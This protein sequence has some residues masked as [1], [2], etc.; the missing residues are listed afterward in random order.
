MGHTRK[1][2]IFAIAP[3]DRLARD[4]E[5]TGLDLSETILVPI[6]AGVDSSWDV[7]DAQVYNASVHITRNRF[8]EISSLVHQEWTRWSANRPHDPVRRYFSYVFNITRTPILHW[9]MSVSLALER[10]KPTEVY[11]Y[12]VGDDTM[13]GISNRDEFL[14]WVR[15]AIVSE[16]RPDVIKVKTSAQRGV[17]ILSRAKGIRMDMLLDFPWYIGVRFPKLMRILQD[18][19]LRRYSSEKSSNFAGRPRV[20]VIAQR[21]K[22]TALVTFLSSRKVPFRTASIPEIVTNTSSNHAKRVLAIEDCLLSEVVDNAFYGLLDMFVDELRSHKKALMDFAHESWQVLMTDHEHDAHVRLL[23]EEAAERGKFVVL[24]PEGV[25]TLAN[26][27]VRPYYGNWFFDAPRVTR[28]AVSEQEATYYTLTFSAE[29]VTLSGY[30]GQSEWPRNATIP[31]LTPLAGFLLRKHRN[32]RKMALVNF[33]DVGPLG[34][35]RAGV[36]DLYSEI[37]SLERLIMGLTSLG[38]AV[39]VTSKT[40]GSFKYLRSKFSGLPVWYFAYLDWQILA[41]ASDVVVQRDSSL[42]PESLNLNLPVIVWNECGL[43]L[44]SSECIQS[45]NGMMILVESMGDLEGALARAVQK[46]EESNKS[47]GITES[48]SIDNLDRWLYSLPKWQD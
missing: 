6:G 14:E 42:G 26:P 43:P 40:G 31:A 29:Q 39:C 2:L 28:F 25:Q 22:S 45:S 36:P 44:A 33:D 32:S 46:N 5:W 37:L 15:G 47:K 9:R 23:A 10:F 16:A 3:I 30:L 20:I 27:T 8:D 13:D 38:W 19:V 35:A 21:R 34:L 41:E 11:L 7:S 48:L 17:R 4:F 24:I 12:G 18:R 1:A